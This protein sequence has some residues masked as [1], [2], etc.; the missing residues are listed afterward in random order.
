M[1]ENYD[2]LEEKLRE[3]EQKI[4]LFG[5]KS[6]GVKLEKIVVQPRKKLNGKVLVVNREFH[7]V[8]IDLGKEDAVRVSDEFVVYRGSEEIG[9]VQVER[10][11]DAMSTA[12]ILA[13][14]QEELISENSVVESL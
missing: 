2:R 3:S 14:S 8:V 9:K 13:G 7:F 1:R 5:R 4:G 12:A 6:S 11:Y 10:V